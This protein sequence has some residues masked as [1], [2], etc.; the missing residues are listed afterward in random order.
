LLARSFCPCAQRNEVPDVA[1]N[2]PRQPDPPAATHNELPLPL[3]MGTQ[4][5]PAQ[6][7]RKQLLIKR[8]MADLV[9]QSRSKSWCFT[10]NNYDDPAQE[11]VRALVPNT[12]FLIYGREVG[13]TGTPHLQGFV[14]FKNRL[15]FNQVAALLP[16]CHLSVARDVYKASDYCR[17]DGDFE[18]FGE[19]PAKASGKR[20]DIDFFKESVDNGNVLSLEDAMSFHTAVYAKYPRFVREYLELKLTKKEEIDLYPLKDWQALVY[21]DIERSVDKRKIIFI[22]DVKGNSG[23][24][25]FAKYCLRFKSNVQY[26]R[27]GK[28]ADMAH[29]FCSQTKVLFVDVCRSKQAEYLQYDFL[30]EV[31]DGMLFSPKYESR[32]KKFCPPHVIVLMNEQPDM[33]KLSEDRYDVRVV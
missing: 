29:E 14:R 33:T 25:W 7:R 18:E 8:I 6:R 21:D 28:K 10:L 27:S 3:E 5:K 11:R 9:P 24:T 31:K 2:V 23:K 1:R 15:R 13:E 19:L 12:E 22:V 30:E 32:V 16:G 26:M 20:S 4:Y 17:K